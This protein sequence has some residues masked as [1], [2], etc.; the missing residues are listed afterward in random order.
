VYL[1][2]EETPL[3][4]R[5]AISLGRTTHRDQQELLIHYVAE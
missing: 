2:R 4:G 1:R 3:W 5:G